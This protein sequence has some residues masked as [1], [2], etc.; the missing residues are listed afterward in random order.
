MAMRSRAVYA[1]F[2][3]LGLGVGASQAAKVVAVDPL[4]E[5]LFKITVDGGW[6]ATVVAFTGGDGL[7]VVDS[8][9]KSTAQDL[10]AT[11]EGLGH[12]KPRYLINTH[13][14]KD[15]TGGNNLL[16]RTAVVIGHKQLRPKL[17]VGSLVLEDYTEDALPRMAIADE[18]TLYFNGEEILIKALGAAHD[19]ADII[20]WFKHARI[21][22]LG[23]LAYGMHYPSI[24]YFTGSLLE[25]PKVLTAILDYLPDGTTIISGHGRNCS[26][27]EMVSFRDMLVD[28]QRIISD[29]YHEGQTPEQIIASGALDQWEDYSHPDMMTTDSYV[30]TVVRNL[31]GDPV[32]AKNILGALYE[33]SKA[34]D[35]EA[36][37]A[38]YR[39]IKL[40]EPEAFGIN[41]DGYQSVIINYL[42]SLGQR[43]ASDGRHADALAVFGILVEEYPDMRGKK[44]LYNSIGEEQLELYRFDAAMKSFEEVLAVSPDDEHARARVELLRGV[45][46]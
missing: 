31:R 9:F 11:L 36:I 40:S 21:A 45:M 15:H 22:Y 2:L 19:A 4:T 32:P 41:L 37:R 5:N 6:E 13:S 24:D 38:E 20:V 12:G 35:G 18:M 42:F 14:H 30:R 34:G 44:I 39:R 33:V 27:R 17:S 46:R 29:R 16:G 7:L 28:T 23:D 25:Y 8:G 43:L 3:V 10:A 1:A 26:Y